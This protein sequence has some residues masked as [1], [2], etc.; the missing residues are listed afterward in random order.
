MSSLVTQSLSEK[1]LVV[2]ISAESLLSFQIKD[3]YISGELDVVH[4]KPED[5]WRNDFLEL[6]K[7][8]TSLYKIIWVHG[9]DFN[10]AKNTIKNDKIT[11][12]LVEAQKYLEQTT[13]QQIPLVIISR[14]ST[15]FSS[16]ESVFKE[17][18]L[19]LELEKNFINKSQTLFPRAQFIFGQDV[20]GENNNIL[21]P[22]RFIIFG[23]SQKNLVDPD[24]DVFF[25]TPSAFFEVFKPQLIKPHTSQTY[26][27]RGKEKKTSFWVD[28]IK[29]LYTQ[30]FNLS[31]EIIKIFTQKPLP[32][33]KEELVVRATS[34]SLDI[35][36]FF[37]QKVR[38]FPS[39]LH[40]LTLG[41]EL[42]GWLRRETGSQGSRFDEKSS[43]PPPKQQLTSNDIRTVKT[44]TKSLLDLSL[45]DSQTK[46]HPI[47][48][49]ESN[50][51]NIFLDR[52][53][54]KKPI[55][56]L[57]IN[58]RADNPKLKV[59]N[60][61]SLK[62]DNDVDKDLQRIFG[63]SRLSS[64]EKRVISKY[65]NKKKIIKKSKH[66]KTMFYGGVGVIGMGMGV[67]L[68]V[69]IFQ[70]GVFFLKKDLFKFIDLYQSRGEESLVLDKKT[71]TS[72]TSRWSGFLNSQIKFYSLILDESFFESTTPLLETATELDEFNQSIKKLNK[73]IVDVY[74]AVVGGGETT[75]N[76]LNDFGSTSQLLFEKLSQLQGK[77]S[78]I[79]RSGFSK[80]EIDKI[81]EF[82]DE[83][84]EK[85]QKI[86]IYS[87]LK[88]FLPPFLATQ[89]KRVYAVLLQNNLELRP[90][91]GFIQAV[92]LLTFDRGML[93]DS[94]VMSVYEVDNK[95][96]S[97]VNPPDEIRKI[98]GEEKWYLRDSNWDPD[99]PTTAQ[100]VTWFIKESLGVSVDGVI[101]LDLNVVQDLLEETG[102]LELPE[103]NEVITSK[104]L[105]ERIE[106]HAKDDLSLD[107][108]N[109]KNYHS[110][111]LQ[112]LITQ[113]QDLPDEKIVPIVL[114]LRN[115]L[116]EK[117][118][119]ISLPK[120]Q[121][122]DVL[123][124]IGWDGRIIQPE[125]PA[126][127]NGGVCLVDTTYQ[128][129]AN[130]GVNK[131]NAYV[132][133]KINHKISVER[134]K[135]THTRQITYKNN[136]RSD[137][138]P[139]GK[140]RTYI[141][142]FT[143]APNTLEKVTLNGKN[144]DINLVTTYKNKDNQ[145]YGIL[146]EVPRGQETTLEIS[147]SMKNNWLVDAQKIGLGVDDLNGFSYVFFDQKQP[148]WI[149][150]G[151]SVSLESGLGLTPKLIAPQAEVSGDEISFEVDRSGH[152]FVG[153]EFGVE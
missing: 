150:D 52:K 22:L 68:L 71:N 122:N 101:A 57:I 44:P 145:V 1:P 139:Q 142:F 115:S 53:I 84:T 112:R 114:S 30:Y 130:V 123:A 153:V 66:K 62:T 138:W 29:T 35:E 90:T 118:L 34:S 36:K 143:K 61:E 133:R 33:F 45:D 79:D 95:L 102:D 144:V 120:K 31:L 119:L 10:D 80:E 94:Q 74:K 81:D 135:I 32:Y 38:S 93:I 28:K 149:N 98:L 86:S 59:D 99:F 91:G 105:L 63:Q 70:L 152:S 109:Q 4:I 140:Y 47:G 117:N 17:F 26:L 110:L 41:E 14:I 55:D 141:R 16:K 76:K 65:K 43:F 103:Y 69:L 100:N 19:W 116:D 60:Y 56:Q 87:Q 127:F 6:I 125:C 50:K 72:V 132:E 92:A 64:S 97:N 21:L 39:P 148:G 131:A 48:F 78:Y 12:S 9:F 107:E 49:L 111:V 128:V 24:T 73:S 13:G 151:L 108:K 37:D 137:N 25:Q 20:L 2:L 134:E 8:R 85:R 129:E 40:E 126:Q 3:L 67:G 7:T 18:D 113:L 51:K 54:N 106:F 27:V 88:S 46:P 124:E 23:L 104:N 82:T 136:S 42:L 15:N 58:T 5:F 75:Q 89:E 77:I 121:E 147:Y 96:L 83:I 146:L 11:T